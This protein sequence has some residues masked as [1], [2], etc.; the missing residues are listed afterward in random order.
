MAWFTALAN[1]ICKYIG[2]NYL[3]LVEVSALDVRHA[4]VVPIQER[5]VQP[6]ARTHQPVYL[7]FQHAAVG[8]CS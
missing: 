1:Y 3:T 6:L 7:Q 8:A 5:I 2:Y 4:G